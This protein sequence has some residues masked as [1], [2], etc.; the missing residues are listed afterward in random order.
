MPKVSEKYI[1]DKKTE[2][3]EAAYRVCTRKPITSVVMNDVIS[4][5]GFSHG[6]IYRYYSDLDEV[7]RDL[8]IK[9]NSEHSLDSR[10]DAIL[11]EAGTDGWKDTVRNVFRLLSDHMIECGTDVMKISIYGDMLAM[12]EPERVGKIAGN[13]EK[14]AQSPL[15]HL[16]QK[17][18]AYMKRTVT[19]KSLKSI[20][21]VEELIQFIVTGY[22]GIQTG[23]VLSGCTENRYR[24]ED[25]FS[26]LAESVILLMEGK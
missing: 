5:T 1:D 23:Y 8:V 16:V 4:E 20:K 2:I 17:L 26:V 19:E 25:M 10:L 22:S 12:S 11:N 7:L 9:I 13:L 15:L 6:A 21:T 3:I 18:E 14:N 24:P